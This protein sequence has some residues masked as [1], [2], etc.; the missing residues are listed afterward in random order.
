MVAERLITLVKLLV[1]FRYSESTGSSSEEGEFKNIDLVTFKV[2]DL[3]RARLMLN[4]KQIMIVFNALQELHLKGIIQIAKVKNRFSQAMNDAI[5]VFKLSGP[6][7]KSPIL[8][9]LQLILAK[10]SQETGDSKAK[11]SEIL[12]HYLYE[13]ERATYGPLS[14]LALIIATKDHRIEYLWKIQ[15]KKKATLKDNCFCNE[16]M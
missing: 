2:S 7:V 13:I 10:H 1:D 4:Q 14:E 9:E 11:A 3:N 15:K 5:I 12:N 16:I 8:C 6:E